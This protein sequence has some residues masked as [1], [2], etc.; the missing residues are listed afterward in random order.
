M[1]TK[2]LLFAFLLLASI[3]QGAVLTVSNSVANPGQYNLLPAAI[4][5]AQAFDTIYV[6]GT[7]AQRMRWFKKGFDTGYMKQGDTFKAESL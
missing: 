6:H 3:A 2:I 4:T 1:K 5:A 7:S